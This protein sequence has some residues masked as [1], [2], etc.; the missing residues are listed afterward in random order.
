MK[1]FT[2]AFCLM[3]L[4]G[5]V[6]AETPAGKFQRCIEQGSALDATEDCIALRTTYLAQIDGCMAA[7]Q[8]AAA[9]AIKIATSGSN[10]GYRARY[11]ICT[12]AVK[13]R[14]GPFG[15]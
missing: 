3:I 2:T 13:S 14:H 10:H 7:P 11:L 1:P 8:V 6:L 4:A 9:E 15:H 5:P 12:R